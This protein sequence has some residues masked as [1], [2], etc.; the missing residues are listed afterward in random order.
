MNTTPTTITGTDPPITV[1]NNNNPPTIGMTVTPTIITTIPP[2]INSNAR[3]PTINTNNTLHTST[4]TPTDTNTIL[5]TLIAT[6]PEFDTN[7]TLHTP[8]GTPTDTNTI[9]TTLLATRPE[10]AIAFANL[11]QQHTPTILINP[12]STTPT[13]ALP[14]LPTNLPTTTVLFHQPTT[15]TNPWI[16]TGH[17]GSSIWPTTSVPTTTTTSPHS[18]DASTIDEPNKDDGDELPY[19]QSDFLPTTQPSSNTK[20]TDTTAFIDMTNNNI[21]DL[22]TRNLRLAEGRIWTRPQIT[23]R[24]IVI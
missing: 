22:H 20:Q 13:N 15:S 3:P 9:L 7:T 5:T 18:H 17:H 12:T 6:R 24:F 16:T 4:D 21:A 19:S 23:R 10:F 14:P 11:I 8:T 1:V 2:N